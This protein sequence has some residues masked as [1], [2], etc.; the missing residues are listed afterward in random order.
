MSNTDSTATA[1]VP[2]SPAELSG[3]LG[4]GAIVFMVIAAAAPLTII[5]GVTPIG[6]LIGNGVGFPALYIIAAVVLLL[7]AVGLSAMSRYIARP[8]AFYTYIGHGLTPAWG[9]GAAFLAILSYTGVQVA[10]F[11]Y[12]GATMTSSIE[13]LGGPSVPWW[14]WAF[15]SIAIVAVLGYRRIQL[16]SRVLGVLL[17]AEMAIVVIL[18]VV[19]IAQGGA[20]GLSIDSFLPDNIFSGN[21]GVGLMFAV[22]GFVGFEATAVFRNEA[23][24]PKR[25]IPRATYLAVIIIGVFYAI[26]AWALVVAWGA[27][28]IVEVAGADPAALIFATM[29][30]YLGPAAGIIVQ[31][32][33]VTSL[34][35]CVL[36]FHNVISRYFHALGS[37][38]ALPAALGRRHTTHGSPH[39]ASIAQTVLSGGLL[40]IFLVIGLDPVTAIFTWFSGTSTLGVLILMAI[41]SVAVI[42]YFRRTRVD[43]RPWQTVVAPVLGLLGLLAMLAVVIAN[44]PVLVGG[45]DLVAALIAGALVA[46]Y[47]AGVVVALVMRSRRPEAYADLTEAIS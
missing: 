17:V 10:V 18:D 2:P 14:L 37:S 26:S 11:A 40:L 24:E 23:K 28:S 36:S 9:L 33:L 3:S 46:A 30:R 1:A 5:G 8:G 21:V 44:F 42:V 20:D 41:A 6:F 29:T 34:F 35:A 12:I 27:D 45:S 16:S 47:V 13:A 7:F 19:V 4:T 22:A 39:V 43:R 32:L 15:A 31:V 38:T 25:T